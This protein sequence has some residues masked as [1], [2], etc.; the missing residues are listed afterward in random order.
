[1]KAA[2]CMINTLFKE[3]SLVNSC[4]CLIGKWP[5]SPQ[6]D[7]HVLSESVGPEHQNPGLPH[8]CSFAA[9]GRQGDWTG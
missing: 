6:S 4:A 2:D 9:C 8:V 1:M 7:V 3:M 5:S